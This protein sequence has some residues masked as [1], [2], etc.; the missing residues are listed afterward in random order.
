MSKQLFDHDP[1]TGITQYYE[2]TE[3]GQGFR[4][5]SEQ[6]CSA[7]IEENKRKQAAGKS[8]YARDPDLW[9][10]GSIPMVLMLKWGVEQGVPGEKLFG[11]EM[12][13]VCGK[14]LNDPDYRHLKTADI[15]V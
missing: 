9:K 3:N 8:Y 15:T 2:P 14:K 12:A 4:I 6:D 13:E 1:W 11:E 5:Y 10:V 7:I